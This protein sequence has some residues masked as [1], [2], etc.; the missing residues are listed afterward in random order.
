MGSRLE[1][2]LLHALYHFFTTNCVIV[3]LCLSV[4]H[5]IALLMSGFVLC[6]VSFAVVTAVVGNIKTREKLQ[7][8]IIKL[9]CGSF[10]LSWTGVIKTHGVIP[11]RAPGQIYVSNHSSMIDMIVLS[12]SHSYSVV[13][14][15]H[16]G[17]VGHIQN[18]LLSCLDCI[19]FNR[20]TSKDKKEAS[21]K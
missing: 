12:Q 16:T 4:I 10:V 1:S 2:M 7:R 14:Q 11:R 9:L 17:W 18:K 13:G 21:R 5:S 6:L 20:A 3:L 8:E 19:W 15:Q